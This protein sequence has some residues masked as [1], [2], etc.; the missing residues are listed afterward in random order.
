MT[1]TMFPESPF[2]FTIVVWSRLLGL[3]A[4]ISNPNLW[5]AV[6]AQETWNSLEQSQQRT[7]APPL[8]EQRLQGWRVIDVQQLWGS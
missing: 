1:G 3:T 4:W 5:P 6:Q 7:T 2:Q 8:S